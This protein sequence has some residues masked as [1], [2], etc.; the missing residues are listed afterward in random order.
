MEVTST[1]I[2]PQDKRPQ[3]TNNEDDAWTLRP[4]ITGSTIKDPELANTSRS[5]LTIPHSDF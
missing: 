3:I 1:S 4:N 2:R 5:I